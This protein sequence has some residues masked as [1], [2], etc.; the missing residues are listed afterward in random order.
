MKHPIFWLRIALGWLFAYA[1]IVK[2]INPAWSAAGYLMSA[3]TF[4]GFYAWLAGPSMI[5]IT[6][7]LNE[8]GL[9]LVGLG[10]LSGVLARPAAYAGALMMV[11]YYFPVLDFPYI[12]EHS[13]LVDEHIIYAFALLLIARAPSL[14]P[15]L[16]IPRRS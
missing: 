5:G 14:G 2:I 7:L 16:R 9:L 12:G 6:N 8:W 1:G 13:L 4:S 3:K 15:I 11:L 10:L